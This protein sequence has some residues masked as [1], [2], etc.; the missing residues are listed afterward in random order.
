M[1]DKNCETCRHRG[2]LLVSHVVECKRHGRCDAVRGPT[3]PS[4]VEGTP[5]PLVMP[6]PPAWKSCVHRSQSAIDTRHC[7]SPG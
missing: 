3:C 5:V 6:R 2:R 7:T 1:P 4:Y